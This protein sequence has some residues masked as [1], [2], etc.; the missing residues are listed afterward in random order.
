MSSDTGLSLAAE[1]V[2]RHDRDR[3]ATA[4]FAP[5]AMREDV[6]VLYAFNLEVARIRESVHEA[7][8]GMI[9]LQWWREVLDGRRDDEAARSPVAGPLLQAARRHA[10]PPALFEEMLEAREADLSPE[11]PADL[12]ALEAYA[13]ATAGALA[14]LAARVLGAEEGAAARAAGTGYALAGLLRA[15]PA[16]LPQGRLTLPAD[17]LR[18]AGTSPEQVLAGRADRAAI[19]AVTRAVG[20]R[21]R[22]I[23]R[24]ARARKVDRAALPAL[25][26]AV[27]ASVHLRVLEQAGWDVFD[28]AV[29]R[30][31]P[32]PLRLAWNALRGRF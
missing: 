26:P 9:R 32:M 31:R 14:E 5:P 7:M 8:A 28:P 23:L 19:A 29:Q 15:V 20:E 13:A 18:Q 1:A 3:F 4:L 12:A 10:L 2:R 6:L 25:L 30:P 24:Q 21:A 17:L 16:H 27:P 22:E 11:P